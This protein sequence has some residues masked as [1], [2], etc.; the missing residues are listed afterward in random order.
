MGIGSGNK[1]ICGFRKTFTQFGYVPSFAIGKN[2]Q[3]IFI[4]NKQIV[5]WKAYELD[6][7]ENKMHS[8]I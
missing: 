2:V 3:F 6:Y 7:D 4:W 8:E 1:F 5:N